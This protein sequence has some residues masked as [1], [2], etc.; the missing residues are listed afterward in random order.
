MIEMKVAD[1]PKEPS[2]TIITGFEYKGV[3]NTIKKKEE[4]AMDAILLLLGREPDRWF[5]AQDVRLEL[6]GEFGN[7]NINTALIKLKDNEAVSWTRDKR[8]ILYQHLFDDS[9]SED[10]KQGVLM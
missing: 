9:D 1:D 10:Q 8:R 5:T 2:E 7:R 3:I 6:G 4:V